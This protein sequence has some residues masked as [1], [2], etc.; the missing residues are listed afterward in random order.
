M[1]ID[2]HIHTFPDRIAAGAVAHLQNASHTAAFSDGTNS[3]LSASMA[4]A[5]IDASLVLPVATNPHQVSRVNDTAARVNDLGSTTGIY[6]F[7]GIHPD[8]PDW[9]QELER[10]AQLGL[11]GIKLHPAYHALPFDHPKYLRILD[12]C[13]QLGLI[14]LTHAGVDIGLP[15][16]V[17]CTPRHI[18]NALTQVGPVK[19]ILAHMGGWRQWDEVE[20]QLAD[21]PVWLDT[22]FCLGN[23]T[24]LEQ[25]HFAPEEL[26]MLANEQF[27]RMVRA[28]GPHRI[29]FG[30]DSPWADQADQLARFRALP[31]TPQE[32]D[33][34]LGENARSLLSL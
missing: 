14:V 11:K 25:G 8:C 2:I 26:T 23:I 3:G 10:V 34:I 19:L 17:Y 33:L 22:A 4:R 18:R 9:Y 13:G 30:T 31:L 24:P 29:L 6:S 21:A 16:P 32:L 1:I 15:T 28:F 5:G 27:V 12:R 20:Q 7:G